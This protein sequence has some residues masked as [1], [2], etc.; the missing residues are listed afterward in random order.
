MA[1]TESFLER[2]N[3]KIKFYYHC[4]AFDEIDDESFGGHFDAKE[5]DEA[6]QQLKITGAAFLQ[7]S[8][9]TLKLTKNNEEDIKFD[10]HE[11]YQGLGMPVKLSQLEAVANCEDKVEVLINKQ[12]SKPN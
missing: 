9:C 7:G 3:N 8:L 10:Y 6:I 1:Y 2:K 5:Y 11:T 12:Y 4:L